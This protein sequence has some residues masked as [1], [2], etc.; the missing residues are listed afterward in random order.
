MSEIVKIM[1]TH[2]LLIRVRLLAAMWRAAL[3]CNFFS[4]EPTVHDLRTA[5]MNYYELC[6]DKSVTERMPSAAGC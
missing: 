6:H 3:H 4:V 5:L 2:F 1:G